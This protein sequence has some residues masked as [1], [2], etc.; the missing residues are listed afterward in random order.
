MNKSWERSRPSDDLTV[1]GTNFESQTKASG[2]I[3]IMWNNE[4]A[5]RTSS[6]NIKV[7]GINSWR[8]SASSWSVAIE[9]SNSWSIDTSS[10][11]VWVGKENKWKIKTSSWWVSIWSSNQAKLSTSSGNVIV[12]IDNAWEIATSSGRVSIK[13]ANYGP[14]S[15]TSGD[16][17]IWLSNWGKGDISTSSGSVKVK[18]K[19]NFWS[20]KTATGDIEVAWNEG[21]LSSVA[22]KIT[23]DSLKITV[24]R[25]GGSSSST[26]IQNSK[27][28]IVTVI[29]SKNVTI[30]GKKVE[31]DT[32]GNK[33][34]ITSPHFDI[35]IDLINDEVKVGGKKVEPT[36]IADLLNY[37][38]WGVGKWALLKKDDEYRMAY[39]QQYITVTK[40]EHSCT[41]IYGH[42]LAR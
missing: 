29:S 19:Y 1:E 7:K 13:Y 39:L 24:S 37:E 6:W 41:K 35:E 36:K 30:N 31:W 40:K 20:I 22:G 15:T 18:E 12:G 42:E 3:K 28:S 2:K 5:L 21:K 23:I 25:E 8:V 33:V 10:G 16:V 38:I 9:E 4:G 27:G 32:T 34:K 14:I 26:I 17:I 11:D